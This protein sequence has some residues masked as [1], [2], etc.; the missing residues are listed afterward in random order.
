M[1]KIRKY[2][3]LVRDNIPEIIV[4]QGN[5]PVIRELSESE[6]ISELEKKMLEEIHEYIESKDV[7][8]L[9]D[10]VEV[11]ESLLYVLGYDLETFNAIR[12]RKNRENGKFEKRIFLECVKEI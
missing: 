3:K 11:V 9:A 6:Y 5:V 1:K 12:L 7:E 4:Q 10:L 8:E 2:D